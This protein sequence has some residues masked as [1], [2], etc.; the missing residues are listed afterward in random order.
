MKKTMLLMLFFIL[1]FGCFA[2]LPA[3]ALLVETAPLYGRPPDARLPG[4]AT[5]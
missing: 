5:P 1:V 3:A 4:S 2:L